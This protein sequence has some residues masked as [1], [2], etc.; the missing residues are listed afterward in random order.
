MNLDD[1]LKRLG[2]LGDAEKAFNARLDEIEND[3]RPRIVREAST[4]PQDGYVW[5]AGEL[6]WMESDILF[7]AR[8]REL[9]A[10]APQYEPSDD[11]KP[12]HVR[13]AVRANR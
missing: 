12:N 9:C 7:R 4:E 3:S 1:E 10:G 5:D 13:D 6:M 2:L 11:T 8:V